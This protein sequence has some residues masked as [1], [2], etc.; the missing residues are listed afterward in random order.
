MPIGPERCEP[1]SPP[2]AA[3][4]ADDVY[5]GFACRDELLAVCHGLIAHDRRDPATGEAV[6]AGI[7]RRAIALLGGASGSEPAVADAAAENRAWMCETLAATLPRVRDDHLHA[8][9]Q[10]LQQR[11]Q[12]HRS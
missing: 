10:D 2:C 4:E 7:L 1:A 12:N 3:A 11:L 8:L 9:L 5:M 6:H